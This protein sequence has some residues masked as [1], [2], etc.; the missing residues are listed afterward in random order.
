MTGTF[1]GSSIPLDK[2]WDPKGDVL[3][4]LTMNGQPLP[5]DHGYPV[6]VVAPGT[7]S[8]KF[9]LLVDSALFD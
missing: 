4:A 3:L 1:Y 8:V 7:A 6:R 2:A 5:R 9:I